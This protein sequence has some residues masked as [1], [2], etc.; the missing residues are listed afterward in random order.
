M[1]QSRE[2]RRYRDARDSRYQNTFLE[3]SVFVLF[4]SVQYLL[5]SKHVPRR[6]LRERPLIV[7]KGLRFR[8]VH[9]LSDPDCSG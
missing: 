5:Q 6:G 8:E 4:M 9:L 2:Y 3:N 1:G 7:P